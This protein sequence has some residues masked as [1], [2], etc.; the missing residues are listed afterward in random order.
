[1]STDAQVRRPLPC[2]WRNPHDEDGQPPWV[3]YCQSRIAI[4]ASK[5]GSSCAHGQCCTEN[6]RIDVRHYVQ[7]PSCNNP[8]KGAWVECKQSF[9]GKRSGCVL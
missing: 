3:R 4:L 6:V 2:I 1:M 7:D 9:R 5:N 8:A